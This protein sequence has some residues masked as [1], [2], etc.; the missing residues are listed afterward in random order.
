MLGASINII[1]CC[2]GIPPRTLEQLQGFTLFSI[3]GFCAASV[4]P[5]CSLCDE[6]RE[7]VGAFLALLEDAAF[8]GEHLVVEIFVR[9]G[10]CGFEEDDV[11][12]GLAEAVD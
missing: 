7:G 6:V 9:V 10:F 5:T 8:A 1:S 2:K 4:P 11:G 3:R 12:G